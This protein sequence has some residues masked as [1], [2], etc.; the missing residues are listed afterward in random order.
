MAKSIRQSSQTVR[1]PGAECRISI[2][3]IDA[4]LTKEGEMSAQ[5]AGI[6]VSIRAGSSIAGYEVEAAIVP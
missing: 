3:G 1:P 4:C 2:P 6:P 5:L